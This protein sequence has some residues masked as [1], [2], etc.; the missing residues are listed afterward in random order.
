WKGYYPIASADLTNVLLVES[1][2]RIA[3]EVQD[4]LRTAAP[5]GSEVRG[6]LRQELEVAYELMRGHDAR[7]GPLADI[8]LIESI[9]EQIQ[10]RRY[11][12]RPGDLPVCLMPGTLRDP[13]GSRLGAVHR[14]LMGRLPGNL[15]QR[16]LGSLC[17]AIAIE[18]GLL[19]RQVRADMW[20]LGGTKAYTCPTNLPTLFFYT[21]VVTPDADFAFREYVKSR[22]P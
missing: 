2:Y 20:R 3:A 8:P 19:N 9:V 7:N 1:F 6:L 10:G 4:R 16:A 13:E 15:E 11:E 5:R 21:P 12:G 22:W 14:G 17:W 18:A